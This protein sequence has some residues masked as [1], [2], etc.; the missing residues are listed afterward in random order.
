MGAVVWRLNAAVELPFV[1]AVQY[2]AYFLG[3]GLARFAVLGLRLGMLVFVGAA[4]YA[5][6]CRLLGVREMFYV[7]GLV[8]EMMGRLYRR[9]E[10]SG[11]SY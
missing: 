9:R 8:G 4:V 7:W 1:K 2:A 6:A 3:N 10:K 5:G 11:A